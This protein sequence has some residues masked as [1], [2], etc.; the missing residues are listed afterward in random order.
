M[1]LMNKNATQ[2]KLTPPPF[3]PPPPPHFLPSWMQKP[4][5]APR[6]GDGA[7]QRHKDG[8]VQIQKGQNTQ[9]KTSCTSL[10]H[11]PLCVCVSLSLSLSLSH[12]LRGEV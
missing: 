4:R 3:P 1:N 8:K 2:I 11:P 7:V 6:G 9:V 5:G 10:T 12:G